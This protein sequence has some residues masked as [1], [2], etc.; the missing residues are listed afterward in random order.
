MKTFVTGATGFIGSALV[1][2]LLARGEDLKLLV[3]ANSNLNMIQGLDVEIV[4]GDI[5]DGDK[6]AIAMKGCKRC[7]HVAALYTLN[8]KPRLFEEINVDGTRNILDGAQKAG[9]ERV[10]YTSTVAAVGCASE[11]GLADEETE[12][13]LG[14]LSIPYI[15]S[16]RRAEVLTMERARQGMDIVVVNPSG[17]VG[18][19]DVKPTPTGKL[20][21]SF[22]RGR[23][24]LVP[25]ARNNFVG[26]E[27]VALGHVLA[28]E[29]GA[30]GGRYILAGENITTTEFLARVAAMTGRRRPWKL[31]HLFA[32]MGGL[33]S[34]IVVKWIFRQETF[35]NRAN[36][37]FLA[38][39][40]SFSI[41]KARSEL[42]W[43]PRKLDDSIERSVQWFC[44]NGYVKD[45]RKRKI[46]D[47]IRTY[48]KEEDAR[49]AEGRVGGERED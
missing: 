35:M 9:V 23:L 3:R 4:E 10:V 11:S 21:L 38:K 16:K 36:V 15:Q 28:M 18:P 14:N 40:M 42:G 30:R 20:L 29:K 31:P 13:N 45:R 27:D 46:L 17:P 39:N 22:I 47:N 33:L 43:V 32:Y 1:R 19:G 44:N 34:E 6:L 5:R 26:V 25:Q 37:K 8:D 7:Y 49:L 2:S 12:W 41:D 48:R 24:P